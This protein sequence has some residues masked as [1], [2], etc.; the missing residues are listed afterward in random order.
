LPN[1]LN[2]VTGVN[3]KIETDAHGVVVRAPAS[4]KDTKVDTPVQY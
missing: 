1:V 3:E 2:E 4:A